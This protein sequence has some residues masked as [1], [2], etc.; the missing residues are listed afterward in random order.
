MLNLKLFIATFRYND[1]TRQIKLTATTEKE[2]T[3]MFEKWIPIHKKNQSKYHAQIPDIELLKLNKL[4][5]S[6]KNAKLFEESYY[7]RELEF[8]GM[9]VKDEA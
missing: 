1:E 5:K 7:K 2:A 4:R 3:E 6:K 9:E 8:L